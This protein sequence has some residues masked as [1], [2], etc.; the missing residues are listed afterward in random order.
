[1]QIAIARL[2]QQTEAPT[3]ISAA[4]FV[5]ADGALYLLHGTPVELTVSHALPFLLGEMR[6]PQRRIALSRLPS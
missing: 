2:N 6:T 5:L 4:A 1:M 3:V